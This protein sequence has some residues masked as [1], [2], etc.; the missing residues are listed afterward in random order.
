[1]TM[2][3]IRHQLIITAMSLAEDKPTPPRKRQTK[4]SV[5]SDEQK[6]VRNIFPRFWNVHV[7]LD[8]Y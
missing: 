4:S 5:L 2:D 7:A 1:M 8:V 6:K 3:E